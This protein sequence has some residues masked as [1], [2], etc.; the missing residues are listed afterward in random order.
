MAKICKSCG[1]YYSGDYCD[2]CGYGKK[3]E[4]S[5]A[6]QKYKKATKPARFQTEEEKAEYAKWDKEKKAANAKGKKK[7][8]ANSANL[9]F[10]LIVAVVFVGVVIFVLYRSGIIFS[11]T[12][13]D[14]VTSYFNSIQ[15]N[16]YDSFLKCFPKEIKDDYENDRRTANLSSVEYLNTLYAD[17]KESYGS[18]YT[19]DVDFGRETALDKDD[20]DMSE[21]EAAYGSAPTISDPYEM[22]VNV[23]F[24]GSAGSEKA[25]LYV[26][27]AKVSGSWKIFNITQDNGIVTEDMGIAAE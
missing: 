6:A 9:K 25:K 3:V 1:N 21:Y 11:H 16:D 8:A 24:K 5:K 12:R 4:G 22:V 27:V 20:Y 13:K 7:G 17:F 14:V 26:N 18:N 19:I 23:T 2:K 15:N 10:L